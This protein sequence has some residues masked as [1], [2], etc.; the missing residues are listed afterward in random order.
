MATCEIGTKTDEKYQ[1]ERKYPVKK[2]IVNVFNTFLLHYR[3]FKVLLIGVV[4][5]VE[6]L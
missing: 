3:F 2:R 4:G 6:N 5:A 1:S